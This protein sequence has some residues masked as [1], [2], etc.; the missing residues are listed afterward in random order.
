[1]PSSHQLVTSAYRQPG[2]KAVELPSSVSHCQSPM[3]TWCLWSL[4]DQWREF[5]PGLAQGDLLQHLQALSHARW[6]EPAVKA[7]ADLGSSYKLV[8]PSLTLIN[9]W[10]GG[11]PYNHGGPLYCISLCLKEQE[12][13]HLCLCWSPRVN[14]GLYRMQPLKCK[15]NSPT[16]CGYR[17]GM[18]AEQ[19]DTADNAHP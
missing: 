1:M 2:R 18:G 5:V 12:R 8:F 13:L 15:S 10:E 14:L 3:P 6:V 17:E 11:C 4:L 9:G 16:E 7:Q 19:R